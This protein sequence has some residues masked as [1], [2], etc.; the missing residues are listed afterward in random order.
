MK[1][2]K[3]FKNTWCGRTAETEK[4][5]DKKYN[6]K[7]ETN[8]FFYFDSNEVPH[9]GYYEMDIKNNKPIYLVNNVFYYT[10]EITQEEISEAIDKQLA[11][12]SKSELTVIGGGAD[13]KKNI[14]RYLD[15]NKTYEIT[16]KE[17]V[18][19]N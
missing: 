16:I 2:V 18:S 7:C 5:F 12:E 6:L 13:V 10:E 3:D 8:R 9:L 17:V 11:E 15:K 14:K 1:K 19:I 4:W